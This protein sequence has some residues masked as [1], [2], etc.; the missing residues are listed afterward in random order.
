MSSGT[1]Q[2]VTT[3][4]LVGEAVYHSSGRFAFAIFL[5]VLGYLSIGQGYTDAIVFFFVCAIVS[6]VMGFRK[7]KNEI[8]ALQYRYNQP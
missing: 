3:T 2:S 1:S 5:F 6:L 7:L 8:N 4:R